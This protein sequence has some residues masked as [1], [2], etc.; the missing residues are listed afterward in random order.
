M[1]PIFKMS[2]I[3]FLS[4]VSPA[5]NFSWLKNRLVTTLTGFSQLKMR[6]A[7]MY[8]EPTGKRIRDHM[9]IPPKKGKH[10]K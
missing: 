9:L 3:K 8:L 1:L 6:F 10:G 5:R 4:V 2:P 7:T